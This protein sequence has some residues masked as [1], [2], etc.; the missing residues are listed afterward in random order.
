MPTSAWYEV[1]LGPGHIVL[2]NVTNVT[3]LPRKRGENYQFSAHVCCGQTTRWIKMPLSTTVGLG[4]GHIVLD[5]NP[6]PLYKKGT[7]PPISAHD[8]C[9]VAKQSP[10]SATA[11]HLLKMTTYSEV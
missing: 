3:Q 1:G 9:G 2:D 8:Y 5:R 6:A 7:Q 4:P 11:E 10:I